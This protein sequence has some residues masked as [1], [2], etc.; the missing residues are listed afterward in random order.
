[1]ATGPKCENCDEK[2]KCLLEIW[3]PQQ[4][5]WGEEWVKKKV[6][7]NCWESIVAIDI[8]TSEEEDDTIVY[9]LGQADRDYIC[10]HCCNYKECPSD[11]ILLEKKDHYELD[12]CDAEEL[13]SHCRFNIKGCDNECPIRK[14]QETQKP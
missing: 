9:D 8:S 5:R 10:S 13:C 11:C 2:S 7:P 12:Q 14:K 6:C 3:I 4:K 1:M